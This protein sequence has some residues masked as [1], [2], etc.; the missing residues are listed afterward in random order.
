MFSISLSL[1]LFFLS[2]YDLCHSKNSL[3]SRVSIKHQHR[4]LYKE[5]TGGKV[6]GWD[7]A[8]A[9]QRPY[10]TDMAGFAVNLQFFLAKPGCYWV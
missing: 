7:I 2:L 5:C 1:F 4:I 10:A 9:P 8:F 6:V 3:A